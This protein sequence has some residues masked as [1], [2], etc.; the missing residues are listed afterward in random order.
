MAITLAWIATGF[1]PVFVLLYSILLAK[2]LPEIS[3]EAV[4]GKHLIQKAVAIGIMV[5]GTIIIGL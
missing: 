2:F 1:Q 5:V 3:K 4:S